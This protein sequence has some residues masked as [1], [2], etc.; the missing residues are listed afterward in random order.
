MTLMLLLRRLRPVSPFASPFPRLASSSTSLFSTPSDLYDLPSLYESELALSTKTSARIATNLATHLTSL[1]ITS[2]TYCKVPS[3]TVSAFAD[4]RGF[5][6]GRP[7]VE[8]V[9]FDAYC[10]RGKSTRYFRGEYP[11]SVAVVGLDRR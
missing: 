6:A 10:G 2:P 7:E 5:L 4:L 8:S 11:P 9:V 3:H 1:N